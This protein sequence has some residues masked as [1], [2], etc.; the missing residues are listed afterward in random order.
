MS[1]TWGFLLPVTQMVKTIFSLPTIAELAN[2][3][4]LLLSSYCK[5]LCN[6]LAVVEQMLSFSYAKL[7]TPA[8]QTAAADLFC[9]V[10][11]EGGRFILGNPDFTSAL[12]PPCLVSDYLLSQHT[13]I[14]A[15]MSSSDQC[16]VCSSLLS[17]ADDGGSL[18]GNEAP[19]R[20]QGHRRASPVPQLPAAADADRPPVAGGHRHCP[21]GRPFPPDDRRPAASLSPRS[22]FATLSAAFPPPPPRTSAPSSKSTGKSSWRPRSASEPTSIRLGSLSPRY[23]AE[24][25][26]RFFKYFMRLDRDAFLPLL[27]ATVDLILAGYAQSRIGSY[28]YCGSV[29]VGEYGCY[30]KSAL[31]PRLTSSCRS[32]ILHILS[33]FCDSTLTLLSTS[34]EAYVQNPNLVEDFY[35]LC[36]RSLQSI[37]NVLFAASDMVLRITQAALPAIQLQ[38]REAN[39]SVMRFLETLVMYGNEVEQE[40]GELAVNVPPYRPQVQSV[41]QVCGQE[42]VNQLVRLRVWCH[43]DRRT[44]RRPSGEPIARL[45]RICHLCFVQP[46]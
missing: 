31:S 33:V 18:H 44:H 17:H 34:P 20:R 12:A 41:L 36:G 4:L 15:S 38:H 5:L 46:F 28:I 40:E 32:V 10:C 42:L 43:V 16:T 7:T 23:V 26:C 9:S 22:S 14:P 25:L 13:S 27:P 1:S 11:K 3:S 6:D 37:P 30:Q 45:Q 21:H 2:T 35:D 39:N 19:Q 8:V 29:L 24:A